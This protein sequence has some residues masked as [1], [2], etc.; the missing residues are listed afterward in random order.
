MEKAFCQNSD[1]FGYR[2]I[3]N[4]IIS[5]YLLIYFVFTKDPLF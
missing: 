4:D 3:K 5:M 2:Y 1:Y